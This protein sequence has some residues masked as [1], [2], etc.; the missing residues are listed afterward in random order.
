MKKF[1]KFLFAMMALA[2]LATIMMAAAMEIAVTGI[3]LPESLT[4]IEGQSA[5]L[6]AGFTVD[7][8]E[9]TPEEIAEAASKL[10]LEWS[11]SDESVATVGQDG[12]V[13]GINFG[14]AT[15]TVSVDG[16]E[17]SASTSVEVKPV[18][19]AL[20]A[21]ALIELTINAKTGEA[22]NP[23]LTPANAPVELTYISSDENVATVNANGFV[24]AVGNGS[25]LII[26]D[27]KYGIAGTTIVN[28][29]TAPSGLALTDKALTI[30]DTAAA[31]L[32]VAGENITAGLDFIYTSSDE[33]VVTVDGE[34][35]I[36]GIGVGS[37]TITATNEFGQSASCTVTVKDVICTYCG[38]E[39]HVANSCPVKAA[40]EAAAAQ[41][42][43]E[44][45]AA[46][47][48]A[49]EEMVELPENGTPLAGPVP[50]PVPEPAPNHGAFGE[51]PEGCGSGSMCP[52][53]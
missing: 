10:T 16:T 40:D 44:E 48:R 25:C 39:G 41:K 24:T 4:L 43:A 52:E 7:K 38:K 42:A 19:E 18:L 11:S 34:G 27:N 47:Q 17:L 46:A 20:E 30:G 6:N 1:A 3:T 5:T 29:N 14:T 22:L 13:T 45:A 28:V 31:E 26:T 49:A 32:T 15:I 2:A 36:N 50:A 53:L 9:A 8:E 21:P 12:V 51:I 35:R 33:T 37:A 23:V